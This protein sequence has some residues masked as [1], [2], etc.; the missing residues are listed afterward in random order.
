M[1]YDPYFEEKISNVQMNDHQV[2]V[3][4]DMNDSK[5]NSNGIETARPQT[6]PNS[7]HF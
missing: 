5:T 7:V 2:L 1:I 4:R 6:A 3:K